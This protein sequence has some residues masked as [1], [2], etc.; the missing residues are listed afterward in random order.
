MRYGR[1]DA[2]GP[3]D[4]GLLPGAAPPFGD[5]S[6]TPAE[7]L[8]KVFYRMGLDDKEIV[9]LSGAHTLGRAYKN[10]SGACAHTYAS[11]DHHATCRVWRRVHQVHQGRPWHQG[12]L[13]V[14]P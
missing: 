10:R 9:A 6:V 13:F 5:G 4:D 11:S 14:D 8:R 7:H 3:A 1:V 2:P 12:W